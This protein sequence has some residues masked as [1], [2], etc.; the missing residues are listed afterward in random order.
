MKNFKTF[1][2]LL[3]CVKRDLMENNNLDRIGIYTCAELVKDTT[4]KI[5]TQ[6]AMENINLSHKEC[7]ILWNIRCGM[8]S[9]CNSKNDIKVRL[10]VDTLDYNL[11]GQKMTVAQMKEKALK[12]SK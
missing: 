7:E 2:G 3:N 10:L 11:I 8:Y 12:E 5:I 1:S 6:Y 4:I 9:Y